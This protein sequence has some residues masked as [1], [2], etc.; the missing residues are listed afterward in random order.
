MQICDT[1][2]TF[3]VRSLD[4]EQCTFL[5]SHICI[6]IIRFDIIKLGFHVLSLVL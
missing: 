3:Y 6:L 5:T 1:S 2:E 4:Y